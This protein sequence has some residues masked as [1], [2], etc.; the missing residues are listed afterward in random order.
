MR[1]ACIAFLSVLSIFGKL[2]GKKK[3]EEK[4]KKEEEL[5]KEFMEARVEA[6]PKDEDEIIKSE[7][8]AGPLTEKF[9]DLYPVREKE[10]KSEEE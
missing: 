2:F 8:K 4:K 1:F 9:F 7:L 6:R 10:E 5:R 3:E